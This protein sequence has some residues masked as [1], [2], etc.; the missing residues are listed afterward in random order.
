METPMQAKDIRVLIADDEVFFRKVLRDIISRIG[1][2]I[3]AEAADGGEAVRLFGQYR[4]HVV[5][6]DIYMPD[7]NGIEATRE[8]I[9]LDPRARVL[10]CSAS[11]YDPDT[12]AA[13]AAGAKAIVMKPFQPKE[14]FES[15]VK[16]LG[17]KRKGA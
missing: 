9:A 5:I 4:P 7:K 6:M 8:I 3:V 1:F 15:V 12:E 10:V 17:L 16:V 11:D 14:I 2:T 13:L